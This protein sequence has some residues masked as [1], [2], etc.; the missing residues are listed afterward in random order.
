MAL[1]SS[2]T[3]G[4][5]NY[6]MGIKLTNA[7]VFGPAFTGPAA[8]VVLGC[9]R[10]VQ[11]VSNK[12][13]SGTFVNYSSSNLFSREYPHRF[14]PE[15]LKALIGNFIPNILILIFGNLAFKYAALCGLNQGII[16]T[17]TSL[18]SFYTSV[19]FYYKFSET[20][21]VSQFV[22]MVLMIVCVVFL[23]LEGMTLSKEK[24][25]SIKEYQSYGMS[26][27]QPQITLNPASSP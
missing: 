6:F 11:A 27:N 25:N 22:G 19:L 15:Q 18:S 24:S 3:S 21:S 8:L 1:I 2:L 12:I 23:A 4:L 9:M 10:I 16:P 14:K 20:V 13:S 17:L 26:T 5:S 7:G